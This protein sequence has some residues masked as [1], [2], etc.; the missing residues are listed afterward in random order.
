MIKKPRKPLERLKKPKVYL[1]LVS[2]VRGQDRA[3]K[4]ACRGLVAA[5]QKR[6]IKPEVEPERMDRERQARAGA[7]RGPLE[8]SK[9]GPLCFALGEKIESL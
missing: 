7:S 8:G 5:R 3:K 1:T 9:R 6:G 2:T 4:R